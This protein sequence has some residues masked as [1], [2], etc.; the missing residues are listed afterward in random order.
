MESIPSTV[1]CV[2]DKMMPQQERVLHVTGATHKSKEMRLE[3]HKCT[4]REIA[5]YFKISE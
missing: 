3:H 5:G 4:E 2:G 1:L